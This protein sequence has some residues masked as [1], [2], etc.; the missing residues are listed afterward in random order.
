MGLRASDIANLKLTDIS[1]KESSISF[2]Q[3]KTGVHLKLPL[4]VD[5]GNSLYRYICE[6]RPQSNSHHVFVHHRAPYCRFGSVTFGRLLKA[7]V[8]DQ[9]ESE[10]I[11]GFHVARKTFASKL[12]ATGNPVTT[13]AAALGHVGVDTVDEYLATCT[14]DCVFGFLEYLE[15]QGNKPGTRNQRLAGLK[16]YLWFAADKDVTLPAVYQLSVIVGMNV[17]KLISPILIMDS[18]PH[19]DGEYCTSAFS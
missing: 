7:A 1:W 13:I 6:G 12:L 11:H 5:V 2:I 19:G 14:R 18:V 17:L 16:S 15:A 3:Q 8:T 10:A 4:P 9:C